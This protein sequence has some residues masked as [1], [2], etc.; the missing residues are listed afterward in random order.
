M[1]LLDNCQENPS[2]SGAQ[3]TELG[4]ETW[5][6]FLESLYYTLSGKFS[7]CFCFVFVVSYLILFHQHVQVSDT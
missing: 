4:L 5:L 1:N 2:K 7:F 3:L 6:V